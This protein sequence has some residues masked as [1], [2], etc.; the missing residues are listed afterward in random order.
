LFRKQGGYD[1]LIVMPLYLDWTSWCLRTR[2]AVFSPGVARFLSNG[3]PKYQKLKLTCQTESLLCNSCLKFE[4]SAPTTSST[5]SPRLSWC[6]VVGCPVFTPWFPF[7]SGFPCLWF[8]CLVGLLYLEVSLMIGSC[9]RPRCLS[10]MS[11]LGSFP[12]FQLEFLIV[13]LFDLT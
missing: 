3:A 11:I 10:S 1:F 2:N 4:A 5:Y 13:L 6:C 7:A 8:P 12:H 9:G